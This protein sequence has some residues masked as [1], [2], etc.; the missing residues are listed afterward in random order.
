MHYIAI[1]LIIV[2]VILGVFKFDLSY[3][4]FGQNLYDMFSSLIYYINK[5]FFNIQDQTPEFV[6]ISEINLA[7]VVPFDIYKLQEKFEY[8]GEYL[9]SAN[10]LKNY[11]MFLLRIALSVVVIFSF[12]IPIFLLVKRKIKKAYLRRSEDDDRYAETDEL[13]YFKSKIE[14]KILLVYYWFRSFLSFVFSRGYYVKILLVIWLLN[15]N[16]ISILACL[17]GIYFYFLASFDI[18]YLVTTLIK[19]GADILITFV[20]ANILFWLVLIYVC[21]TNALKKVAYMI[22]EHHEMKNRGFINAQPLGTLGCATMGAGKTSLSVDM[23]L[24]T[25]V[26]FKDKALEILIKYDMKFPNFPWLQFEDDLKQCY[27]NHIQRQEDLKKYGTSLVD[28]TKTI[29]N[30]ASSKYWV[31][32]KCQEFLKNPCVS[33]LWG[34]DFEKYKMECDDDLKI[35]DLFEALIT[36]SKVYLIYI[37]QTSYIFGNL[38]IRED[39]FCDD[40]YLPLWITDFF[41]RSPSESIENSRFAKIFDY[42]MF[43]LG[44]KMLENN[45]NSNAFEFGV[46]VLT[47]IGKERKNALENRENKKKDDKANQS[48][49]LF[50]Y[51]IKMIRHRATVDFFPFVRIIS[52]EQR[53]ESLGADARDTFSVIQIV[54]KSELIV[55][56]KGLFFDSFIHNII[57]PKFKA[58]YLQMRNLRCDNTLLIYLLKNIFA[59]T[60]NRYD[61]LKNRFGYYTLKFETTTGTLDGKADKFKYYLSTKKTYSD[62]FSTD[63]YSDFFE[64]MSYYS[65]IGIMDFVSYRDTKQEDDEMQLQ[66]AYFYIDMS[67]FT[68]FANV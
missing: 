5:V 24:S 54:D 26:M 35:T 2:S 59:W 6:S 4:R 18:G 20:S 22:L 61:K 16:V 68:E 49:D 13:K 17:V 60:E 31:I 55:L 11:L 9:I 43:R 14:P 45:Q 10:N 36:Y 38:S 25:S 27:Q 53:P 66:N 7:K 62:R 44:K 63:C 32:S 41:H 56:Y 37:V 51:S 46:V 8:F 40:G 1:L 42:D 58:F 50:N 28:V 52:D 15:L 3:E 33:N 34:Y 29:Y 65:G 23:A 39:M 21:L 30:L 12:L 64:K 67:Q 48:N 47:E 57:Y 19:F